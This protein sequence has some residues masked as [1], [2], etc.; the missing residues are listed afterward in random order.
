MEHIVAA[1][2][3]GRVTELAVRPGDQVTRGGALATFEA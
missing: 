2:G 3:P 1:N